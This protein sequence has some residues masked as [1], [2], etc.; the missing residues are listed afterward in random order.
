MPHAPEINTGNR[1]LQAIPKRV[2]EQLGNRCHSVPLKRGMVLIDPGVH[3]DHIYFPDHG[4][5]S[6]VK[7]MEDGRTAEVG[8]VGINGMVGIAEL[9]GM[10]PVMIES[11]VQ[12]DGTARCIEAAALRDA[13]EGS[14]ELRQLIL[15]W[16]HYYIDQLAQT[17]ACN[18]L[19]TLRQRCCRWLLTAHDNAQSR[20][21][22]LTHE[23]LALMMGVNR[24][25]LSLTVAALQR[26]G[27]VEYRRASLTIIDRPGLERGA[28]E[29][30]ETL[31]QELDRV[32]AAEPDAGRLFA[33]SC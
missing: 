16:L 23:F 2:L 22:T 28:C 20:T 7:V 10:E 27:M 33:S 24:P 17:A 14:R 32:T 3:T 19:H 15:R 1:L 29:C 18:R 8:A 12:I 5:V 4:L 9:L 25:S 6:L 11:I 30:Y 21:F 31:Q 26:Q 13:V